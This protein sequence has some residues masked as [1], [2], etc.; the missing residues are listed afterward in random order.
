MQVRYAALT[1][2]GKKREH[3]EDAFLVDDNVNLFAVCDGMGG[4]AAGEVASA[5]AVDTLRE[6]IEQNIDALTAYQSGEADVERYEVIQMMEHAIQTACDRIYEAAQRDDKK[7]GMGTTCS[8]L[9]VLGHRGF[10]GHVGD[11]RVY[12]IRDKMVHQLTEDHSLVNELVRRGKLK[13]DEVA[14]SPYA[15]YK[16]AVT[17]AVGVYPSVEG[18]TLDFDVLPGDQFLLCSD[19]LH[20]YLDDDKILHFFEEEDLEKLSQ[21]LIDLANEGGGHDNITAVTVRVEPDEAASAEVEEKAAEV[22]LTLEMLRQIPLFKYATYKEL[23]HVVN[24]T[25]VM[26][27]AAGQPVFEEGNEGDY[28]Y[29]VMRGRVRLH[30]GDTDVTS[31]EPGQHFGEMALVDRAPRSASAT[32]EVDSRLLAIH[33]SDFYAL[34]RQETSLSVKIL[35]SFVQVLADRLRATTASLSEARLEAEAEDLTGEVDLAEE[36]PHG[37]EL[38]A[39]EE[40]DPAGSRERDSTLAASAQAGQTGTPEPNDQ[41]APAQAGSFTRADTLQDQPAPADV[42]TAGPAPTSSGPEPQA[43][44]TPDVQAGVHTAPDAAPAQAKAAPVASTLVGLPPLSTPSPQESPV[45]EPGPHKP[46]PKGSGQSSPPVD[47]TP[48]DE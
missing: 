8:M 48:S 2:V 5:I 16:N 6:A 9:M 36:E 20:Y 38:A 44:P 39:A 31:F 25:E 40:P 1:D 26:D 23:V 13:R 30:K 10:I 37:S 15:E 47:P 4:H 28:L 7:R 14:S 19:G 34:V 42:V 41:T 45:Q 18:D 32:A 33:R 12:L 27:F 46:D 11:S 43:P 22:N 35:W 24:I 17:R 29:V 3:N 21:G